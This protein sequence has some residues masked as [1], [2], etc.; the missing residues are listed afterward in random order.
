M[1]KACVPFAVVIFL[2]IHLQG[3]YSSTAVGNKDNIEFVKKL[4]KNTSYKLREMKM[5]YLGIPGYKINFFIGTLE[6]KDAVIGNLSSLALRNAQQKFKKTLIDVATLYDF[7]LTLGFNDLVGQLAF[8]FDI[9]FLY[10][11]STKIRIL[12]SENTLN[13]KG[14]IT[15]DGEEPG[16]CSINLNSVSILKTGK[17]NIFLAPENAVNTVL[18]YLLNTGLNELLPL[19]IP[20]VNIL[21]SAYIDDDDFMNSFTN[22]ICSAIV[23]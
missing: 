2:L 12:N 16:S 20:N 1:A 5:D 15:L 18:T 8:K 17:F 9:G 21:I 19:V 14:Q 10:K 23:S 3:C 22:L 13:F 6:V 7:D 11:G 4:I